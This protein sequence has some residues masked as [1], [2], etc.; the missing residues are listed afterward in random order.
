M[1]NL[2]REALRLIIRA[3]SETN[4]LPTSS[5]RRKIH[6]QDKRAA[7]SN[8]DYKTKGG[9]DMLKRILMIMAVMIFTVSAAY[10][11]PADLPKTGQTTSYATRDD[12]NLQKG[13][14]WPS[15]RFTVGT[16]AEVNCV[17]DN[18]T[19]LMWVKSP[20]STE[21]KWKQAVDYANNLTLCG[22]TDWRFPNVNELESLVN[23]EQ[24]NIASWL[25]TQGFSNVPAGH[26]WSSTTRADDTGYAWGVHMWAGNVGYVNKAVNGYVWPVRSGQ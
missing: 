18:L 9:K 5:K 1:R 14:A 11:A 17:T 19:G 15:P 21:R 4:R 7:A 25:N 13:F 23:V 6:Q 20:D 3:N 16:V 10:A 26:Y 2:S 22:Y 8:K 24:V 12:G